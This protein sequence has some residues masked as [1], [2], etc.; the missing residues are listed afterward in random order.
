M[1]S[2]IRCCASLLVHTLMIFAIKVSALQKSASCYT[3]S[4]TVVTKRV[5]AHCKSPTNPIQNL[6]FQN[7]R[8]FR[9]S[10]F[11]ILFHN[12]GWNHKWRKQYRS[13]LTRLCIAQSHPA[14]YDILPLER[15]DA[16]FNAPIQYRGIRIFLGAAVDNKSLFCLSCSHS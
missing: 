2:T 8:F 3:C 5:S 1:P 15:K 9:L 4:H 7:V 11:L 16:Q 6:T 14:K 12:Q 10:L 13:Y